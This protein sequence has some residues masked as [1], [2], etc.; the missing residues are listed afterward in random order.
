VNANSD[1]DW[2]DVQALQGG[3]DS[4]LDRLMARHRGPL[5]AFVSR[6]IGNSGD[7]E[8]MAQETFVRAYFK[9]HTFRPRAPFVAWLYQIARNL[10][11]DYFRSRAYKQWILSDSLE[12]HPG[13]RSQATKTFSDGPDRVEAVQVALLKLPIKLRESLI[14]TAIEGFSQAEAAARLGLSAKAVEVRSYR[15]RKLLERFLRDSVGSLR[16]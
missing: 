9:I 5:L 10:C 6:M 11:R 4:A 3:D 15:A 12:E 1:P 8:E 16:F 14:L 13:E 2:P 7:A